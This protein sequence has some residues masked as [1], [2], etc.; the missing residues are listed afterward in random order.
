MIGLET[1]RALLKEAASK[2]TAVACHRVVARSRL[3]LEWTVGSTACFSEDGRYSFRQSAAKAAFQAPTIKTPLESLL[4]ALARLAALFHDLGKASVAFQSKL[5]KGAGA[6]V[7]RHDVLSF[8]ILADSLWTED[9]TE[10]EW[11]SR[12]AANPQA[13]CRCVTSTELVP[14]DSPWLKKIQERLTTEKALFVEKTQLLALDGRAP[15]LLTVLWLVLTHHRLPQGDS[16][17]EQFDAGRYLNIA[18][19][20][21]NIELAPLAECLTPHKGVKPWEDAKW[22]AAVS[23]AARTALAAIEEIQSS[24]PVER[25]AFFWPQVA[26]HLLRPSLILSDHLGSLQADKSDVIKK[27]FAGPATYANLYDKRHAGDTL[28][29]HLTRVAKLTRQITSASLAPR[30]LACTELP[31]RS[32]VLQTG[33]PPAYAWQEELHTA[34]TQARKHGPVFTSIIAETGAGKTLAGVRAMHATSEGKLRFTLALGLRSLTWQSAKSMLE[35]ARLPEKD[36]TVAVGQPQ[37]LGLDDKALGNQKAHTSGVRLGSESAE[38]GDTESALSNTEFS[39]NWLEGICSEKEAKEYWGEPALALLSAPVVAC[40]VDHLVSAVTL[41]R[42]GDSKLFLRQSTSDLV[43]DE[44]DSYSPS[45]LQT[46]GKLAYV[47]GLHGRNVV[48]MSATMSP[49]VQNGLFAAWRA[50]LAAHVQLKARPLSFGCVFASNNCAPQVL[51]SPSVDSVTSAWE[52]FA[53]K[54]AR[55]Y[56]DVALKG[57]RRILQLLPLVAKSA[58]EAFPEI[59]SA[60]LQL[61]SHHCSVDPKTGKR[62][63]IGFIRFNTAKTAWQFA[64][65]LANKPWNTANQPD[66]RFIAYHSKFPRTHLGVLDATLKQLT[67]RKD[68]HA[69]LET[70]SLRDVL[71]TTSSEDVVILVPTTTLIETGRDFDFDWAILEPRSVRGEVQA[72]GRVRRHRREALQSV[73][74]NVLLLSQPLKALDGANVSVWSHPG[75]EDWL[76]G[77]R[78]SQELPNLVNEHQLLGGPSSTGQAPPDS[79]LGPSVSTASPPPPMPRR[80]RPGAVRPSFVNSAAD[81]L[82]VTA[83]NKAIDAQLCLVMQTDYAQNRIGFLEQAAQGLH[84]TRTHRASGA[85]PASLPWYLSSFAPLNANHARETPFRGENARTALFRPSSSKVEFFDEVSGQYFPCL[86]A[87][88]V[89]IV[90]SRALIPDLALQAEKLA[91]DDKHIVCAA[92][93]CGAGEASFKK[94]KWSPLL[95]FI[96]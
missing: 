8:L 63:S 84:L 87:Q 38:G 94:L 27:A 31:A 79:A 78:V 77:L 92:L 25:P 93:R 76:P 29:R 89:D 67:T 16:L 70:P 7:L 3:E 30:N 71:D 88:V 26:A 61:H 81:A 13:A 43:L 83:W 28:S 18:N 60:A 5:K 14:S 42:G 41:L 2:T 66:C 9:V 49:P 80:G 64:E 53:G 20:S 4:V 32:P 90:S 56:A 40:T 62:V 10:T 73:H 86:S 21:S 85:L 47:A 57:R 22:Q 45:D 74:P 6:E 75:V 36:V 51:E 24:G 34:C 39:V 23:A 15:G 1:L 50:G 82:P 91:V 48:V 17:A 37:T 72:I 68:A 19:A 52:D 46:I 11:L 59:V 33:L 44:I 69:F 55:G 65:H 12:L 35:D 96:E 95:G 54:V 58:V